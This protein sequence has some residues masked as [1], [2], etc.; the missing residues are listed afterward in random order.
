MRNGV[1]ASLLVIAVLAGAGAGYL[2][3]EANLRTTTVTST[4]T[5]TTTISISTLCST[6]VAPTT[7]S[8]MADVYVVSPESLGTICV[9]YHFDTAGSWSFASPGYGPLYYN[10]RSSSFY[11]CGESFNKTLATI[12]STLRISASVGEFTHGADQNVS[13]A[14]TI[15]AENNTTGVFWLFIGICDPV[16]VAIGPVPASVSGPTQ[17]CISI[18][19]E[20]SY[21]AVTGVSNILVS[22]VPTS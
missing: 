1:V 22:V 18:S 17:T 6:P 21:E 10:P 4:T 20:P 15:A 5:E 8:G 3:S 14:Y 2:V 16:Y 19:G 12:C 11:G 13:V 9:N 7:S